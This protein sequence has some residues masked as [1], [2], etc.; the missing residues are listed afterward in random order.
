MYGNKKA[1]TK[2]TETK[3]IEWRTSR[4]MREIVDRLQ[5]KQGIEGISDN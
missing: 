5:H 3:Y 4:I 1:Q 2:G